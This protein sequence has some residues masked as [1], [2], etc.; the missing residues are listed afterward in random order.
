M[1]KNWS[2]CAVTIF[3]HEL[4]L[5]FLFYLKKIL[6]LFNYSCM[7]FLPIPPPH[8]NSFQRGEMQPQ[9]LFQTK[10]SGSNCQ[11]SQTWILEIKPS[12]ALIVV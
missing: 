10:T 7:P 1:F 9:N 8:P 5:F 4:F 6:L 3:I 11:Q 2:F 12:P